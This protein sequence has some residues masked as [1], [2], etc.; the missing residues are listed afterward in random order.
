MTSAAVFWECFAPTD[1]I[2]R[3]GVLRLHRQDLD[4]AKGPNLIQLQ[5]DRASDSFS[6]GRA[7][8]ISEWRDGVEFAEHWDGLI[9]LFRSAFGPWELEILRL[10]TPALCLWEPE[11][12]HALQRRSAADATRW[13]GLLL[14]LFEATQARRCVFPLDLGRGPTKDWPSRV[15]AAPPE[16]LI[17]A[18][19]SDE[20]APAGLSAIALASGG[21]LL[22]S[23]PV[24]RSP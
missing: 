10:G 19:G 8:E 20:A 2:F 12:T 23:L 5:Y 9:V 6:E 22:T 21:R 16:L 15:E 1:E 14:D 3:K 24:K 17:L 11:K 13:A 18:P 7:V 4:L